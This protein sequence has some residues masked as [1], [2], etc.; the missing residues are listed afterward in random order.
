[1][2]GYES[3]IILDPN[4]SEE[5]QAGLLAKFKETVE[6]KGGSVV[7]QVQW[8]RRKLAYPVRKLDYGTYYLLYLDRR[9]E[10]LTALENV[11]RLDEGVLKWQTVSVDDVD[12]EFTKFEKLK[13]EG[14]MAQTLS[15][16]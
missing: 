2:Q 10:A 16:R 1:M 7:H 12:T 15:D 9:P 5:N 14:S 3:I 13:D 11:L 6:A 8:G 4:S